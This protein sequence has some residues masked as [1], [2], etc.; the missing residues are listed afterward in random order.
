[1]A[2]WFYFIQGQIKVIFEGQMPKIEFLKLKTTTTTALDQCMPLNI[3]YLH[4]AYMY[5]LD[6]VWFHT[7]GHTYT[8]QGH[9]N[10]NFKSSTYV[11]R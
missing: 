9:D 2:S 5:Y 7:Q 11:F 8:H 4:I 6:L 3:M 1:M 10:I